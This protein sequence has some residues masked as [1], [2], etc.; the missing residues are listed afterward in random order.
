MKEATNV[1]VDLGQDKVITFE[2]GKLAKQADGSI[3]ARL[4]DTMVL[5]TAVCGGKRP[6]QNFFPLTVEYREKYYAGGKIPGGFMKRGGRPSDGEIVSARLIDR[7]IRPLFPDGFRNEVQIIVYVISAD[8]ENRSDVVAGCAASAALLL[9]GMPFQGPVGEVRVGRVDG[10]FVINPTLEQQEVSDIDLI[11][12]GKI[13]SI[14]MVEGEMSEISEDDMNAAISFGHDAVIK[15][16]EAQIELQKAFGQADAMEFVA[17]VTSEDVIEAV[18]TQF[19][20]RLY[21]HIKSPYEKSSFY[22]GISDIKQEAIVHFLGED[23]PE[24]GKEQLEATEQGWTAG[25][26]KDAVGEVEKDVLRDLILDENYRLDGRGPKDIR[27]IWAEVGYLPRS[28]GSSVFTRG[29]TQALAALT[30]GGGREA[31]AVDDLFDDKDKTF[32]LHYNF[33]PFCVGEARMIRGTSRREI[34]HGMLAER[35]LKQVLPS[36]DDFPYT[37]RVNSEVLESNGSSSMATVCA[38]SLAMMDAGVPIRTSVAGIAMGL[39]VDGDRIAILS[40][41]LGT[42]DHLGDMD[43]K[44]TGTAEGITACQMDVKIKGG[45]SRELMGDALAQAKEGRMHILGIMDE[46]LA[47][48]RD[49]VSQFAP[50]MTTIEVDVD[51]IGAIIGPGGKNIQALQR[52]TECKVDIEEKDGKGYVTISAV[53]GDKADEAIGRIMQIITLPE[54]G[55]D[56]LG[57][58]VSLQPFGAII[59]IMPGHEGLLHISE[60][61]YGYVDDVNDHF[62][63]GDEVKVRLIEVKDGGKLRLSMK[64]FLEKP[65]GWVE[66]ERNERRGGG[67]GGDRRGGRGGDRRGGGGDRRGGGGR[68]RR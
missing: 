34:G 5:C 60:I 27:P 7:C 49:S 10:E 44:V 37:M 32:Y 39:V 67:R 62:S 58:I 12:A 64:P 4:G 41:I 38:G 56:Y 51:F 2:T 9:T 46:V 25:D 14:T 11:V 63:M 68:D 30:L 3:V 35:S 20:Q 17:D 16:C 6:G 47:T 59:E 18:R 52:E 15:V 26:I 55:E 50:R 48:P 54:E 65:E 42:E 24:N 22:G 31:Q 57:K 33:P 66:P 61:A 53:D 8:N 40:D 36:A 21:D 28:H 19:K 23:D 43:F 45:L 29:E 1:S 13:D